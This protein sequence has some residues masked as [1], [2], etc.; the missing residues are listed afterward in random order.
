MS[1][2]YYDYGAGKWVLLIDSSNYVQFKGWVEGQWIGTRCTKYDFDSESE[3]E[4]F[5]LESGFIQGM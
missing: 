2:Y 1:D 5:I 3:M 4:Q